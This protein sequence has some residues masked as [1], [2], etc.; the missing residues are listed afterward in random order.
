MKLV[1]WLLT[2]CFEKNALVTPVPAK[3]KQDGRDVFMTLLIL[4]E[5]IGRLLAGR[6]QGSVS[7]CRSEPP[8]RGLLCASRWPMAGAHSSEQ[9][10]F[11][12]FQ[13]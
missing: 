2:E 10:L 11:R 4:T 5:D 13:S 3:Q 7:E 1:P 8:R 6:Y 12:V 9:S